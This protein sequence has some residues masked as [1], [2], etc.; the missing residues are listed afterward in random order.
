MQQY[1]QSVVTYGGK[2]AN[3]RS[4]KSVSNK[5]NTKKQN[6]IKNNKMHQLGAILLFAVGLFLCALVFVEGQ[7]LWKLMHDL[8]LGFFGILAY[9]IGALIMIAAVLLASNSMKGSFHNKVL[10][11]ITLFVLICTQVQI[12]NHPIYGNRNFIECMEYAWRDGVNSIGGGL[13]GGLLGLTFEYALGKQAAMV[14]VWILIFVF[15][16]IATGSTLIDFF[17][18]IFKPI[19]K[20]EAGVK[21]RPVEEKPRF[22]IDVPLGDMPE[23]PVSSK[24]FHVPGL[25]EPKKS[26]KKKNT[27][28]NATNPSK[29]I[30]DNDKKIKQAKLDDIVKKAATEFG[31]NDKFNPPNLGESLNANGYI[32][33][34][35]NLLKKA[36]NINNI[37]VSTELRAN[38]DKLVNTLR[39]FGVETRIIDICRGPSVTRYELQ[40]SAGVKISKITNL[41]DD[42][43][44]NLA[45][46]GVRIEA[47]IP[48]K[49]AVGIEVPNKNKDMVS[50][51]EIVSSEEFASSSS[52][53]TF[54][55][56]KDIAGKVKVADIA[57]MPHVLVA[58]ATG[59]G[60]SVCINS[61]IISLL[62]KSSP[63]DVR[64]LMI[65]PK[66]VE[67]GGYNGIPHLLVPVVTDPKK[68]SGALGWAVTEM[69]NRYK[70]FAETGVRDLDGYNKLA[71]SNRTNEDGEPYAKMP[72][73]V[74]IIDELADLMMAASREVEDSICRLA[75]MARAAGMHLVIA[76]QRPSVDVIT[77]V[78]K[79]NIPSRIAF[80]VS[81]QVDSRTIIDSSGA[82][83]LL[84]KGDMLYYP[85]DQRK[86]L[87][88]QGCFVSDKEVE[89]VVSFIKSREKVEYSEDILEE[90]ERQ[91]IEESSSSSSSEVTEGQDS[92]IPAAIEVIVET[93]QASTSFL[94]RRLKLGYARAARIMDEMESRGIVGPQDGSKRREVLISKQQWLEMQINDKS[95]D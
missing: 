49:A 42:I 70:I 89:Q 87:R 57:K 83:K 95:N 71:K 44:L 46:G 8:L 91:S 4:K 6:D 48:N 11:L 55:L 9:F 18:F 30:V 76:T 38:A 23:H 52:S 88:I 62:Y 3:K 36:N 84:G 66:V 40:P 79:A 93:G 82:E 7:N 54:A 56:G 26:K 72:Q 69:L 20:I 50:L 17:K 86:P 63:E 19:K 94:Q 32:F 90:I 29:D 45:S 60:K 14:V 15:S 68:A 47:P 64:L 61:I 75:Q 80:T 74:I 39:S 51:R 37:D 81:S 59:S 28:L 22:D 12:I 41:A 43:S 16:L 13:I 31:E 73:I 35:V 2:M 21:N 85:I 53:L 78:I 1:K 33:P 77:G 10:E 27:E 5:P 92:M 34:S 65:D 58:G 25:E 67:L 24:N